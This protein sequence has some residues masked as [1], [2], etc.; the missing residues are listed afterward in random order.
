MTTTASTDEVVDASAA[1]LI[2]ELES[3]GTA[4]SLEDRLRIIYELSKYIYLDTP[5]RNAN[6]LKKI[7]QY[8]IIEWGA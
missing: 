6:L 5:K 3:K 1:A 4:L 8:T 7:H 2:A